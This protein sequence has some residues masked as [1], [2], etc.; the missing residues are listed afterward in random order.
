MIIIGID[1]DSK[2]H[3][4]SVYVDGKLNDL[5]NLSLIGV[6]ELLTSEEFNNIDMSFIQAHIEDVC[7]NNATFSKSFIKNQAAFR[8]V[9]NSVGRCQQAQVELERMLSHLGVKVVKHKISS[10]WKKDKKQ[11]EL[12]TG[13]KGKSNEDTRSAAYFGYLGV[14][15]KP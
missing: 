7:A 6:M 11:F 14:T 12:V 3:G 13:W 5:K 10:A 4:V 2:E 8:K 9:T 15:Y 1:P